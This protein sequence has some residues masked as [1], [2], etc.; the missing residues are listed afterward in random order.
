MSYFTDGILECRRLKASSFPEGERHSWDQE[1]AVHTQLSH[2]F[3]RGSQ[4]QKQEL[5]VQVRGRAGNWSRDA[6][7]LPNHR[8]GKTWA[9]K[10]LQSED[11]KAQDTVKQKGCGLPEVL[12]KVGQDLTCRRS[13]LPMLDGQAR[14]QTIS[15]EQ[16]EGWT[17]TSAPR[18]S[19]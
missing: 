10:V 15:S 16:V 9:A 19:F 3:G 14:R 12:V 18:K 8:Q 11:T 1:A 7:L 2:P 6:S 13:H 17:Q 5:R 4:D